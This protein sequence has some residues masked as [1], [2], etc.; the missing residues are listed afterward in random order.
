V[1]TT[2]AALL[3]AAFLQLAACTTVD[4]A[5]QEAALAK[6]TAAQAAW[7]DLDFG[8]LFCY[9]LHVNPALE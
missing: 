5:A 4:S 2:S 6:P 7:Q 1:K 3:S 9:I 8:I